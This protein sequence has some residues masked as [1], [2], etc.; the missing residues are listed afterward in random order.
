AADGQRCRE[1]SFLELHHREP[2]ARRP[3]ERRE[4]LTILPSA[5]RARRRAGHW[6]RVHG[7]AFGARDLTDKHADLLCTPR[8]RGQRRAGIRAYRFQVE[9][10]VLPDIPT[11][12]LEPGALP[13]GSFGAP[14]STT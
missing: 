8:R 2:Y 3:C 10:G 5:Q 12:A 14:V 1:T 11:S 9:N 13:A 6:P 4:S 7:P